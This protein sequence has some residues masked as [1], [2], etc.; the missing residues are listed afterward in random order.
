[1]GASVR[2]YAVI[3]VLVNKDD[4]PELSSESCEHE[5]RTGH[6]FCPVC[7]TKVETVEKF[8]RER[9]GDFTDLGWNKGALPTGYLIAQ[10]YEPDH[11]LVGW[12]LQAGEYDRQNGIGCY[13]ATYAIPPLDEIKAALRKLFE[14]WPELFHEETFGFHVYQYYA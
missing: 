9:W 4:L 13:A 12:G 11:C 5:Q 10:M 3:G 8:N 6:R 1:M 14:P 2:A 7:G